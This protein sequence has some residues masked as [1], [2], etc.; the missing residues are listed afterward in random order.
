[1]PLIPLEDNFDDVI[2]KVQRGLH[3]SDEDLA[4]RSEV[5][6]EDLAK[7]KNGEM[8]IAVI[9]RVARHLRL[10]PN[11]LEALARKNWYPEIPV[12]PRGFAAFNTPFEDMTVNSY[13]IWDPKTKEAAAFDTGASTEDM[14]DVIKT[15]RLRLQYI[16]ITHTHEDHIIDLPRLTA[17]FPDAEVWSH[18]DAPVEH[19]GAQNFKEGVHFHVGSHDIKTLLT[20]GHAVGQTT[21][22]VSGLSWPLAV[23][24]DSLFASSVGGSPTGFA[25]QL[26]TNRAKIFNLPRDTVIAPGHG[27]LTTLAQEKKHNPVFAH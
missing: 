26:R 17:A 14:I 9:R 24:G 19:P 18:V 10:N 12:F 2:N 16:F 4:A 6:L 22:F 23:V 21:F 8:I 11:A 20:P 3:I 27:P 7:V 1:M 15:E 25:E 5:T 13:L